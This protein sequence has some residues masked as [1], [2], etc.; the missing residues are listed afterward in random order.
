MTRDETIALLREMRELYPDTP[1]PSDIALQVELWAEALRDEDY[2]TVHRCLLDYFRTD[3]R[4]FAPKVGQLLS[5]R[6]EPLDDRGLED[7]GAWTVENEGD[8]G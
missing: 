4:G 3:N 1:P 6:P 7:W 2:A 5:L 8:P